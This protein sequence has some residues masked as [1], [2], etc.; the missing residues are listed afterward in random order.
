[1]NNWL[2]TNA[3]VGPLASSIRSASPGFR[4]PASSDYRLSAN[5]AAIGAA[6]AQVFGLPGKE[7]FQNELTNRQWRVRNAARDLGAFE[8]TSINAPVSAYSS[9]PAPNLNI[10]LIGANTLLSWPLYA[11]EFLL[12]RSGTA[13]PLA[14]TLAT[15]SRI[16][17]LLGISVV[18]AQSQKAALFRL[19]Q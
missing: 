11:Q 19:K 2:Q 18:A 5:S 12:Y 4:D 9:A 1:L 15:D 7:Y 16:T 3:T 8:S 14:W 17:N 6:S 13:F 10:G